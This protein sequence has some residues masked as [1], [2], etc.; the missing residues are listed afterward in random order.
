MELLFDIISSLWIVLKSV[1]DS[2]IM[3]RIDS[4]FASLLLH[5]SP[6]LLLAT[7]GGEKWGGGGGGGV[8]FLPPHF[9]L[10]ANQTPAK[11]ALPSNN[12]WMEKGCWGGEGG[13]G[14]TMTTCHCQCLASTVV[15]KPMNCPTET[16]SSILGVCASIL[17]QEKINKMMPSLWL[18]GELLQLVK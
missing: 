14:V 12:F 16:D 5:M 1:Y 7:F 18:A 8:V 9:Y 15:Y 13:E 17:D 4:F 6:C 2:E 11:F 3:T 10:H